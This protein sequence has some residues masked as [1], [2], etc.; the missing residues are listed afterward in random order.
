MKA[1]FYRSSGFRYL[2]ISTTLVL[3]II[4]AYLL[5]IKPSDVK[6][7]GS[8]IGFSGIVVESYDGKTPILEAEMR[9]YS[10]AWPY[11]ELLVTIDGIDYAVDLGLFFPKR[12]NIIWVYAP[13]HVNKAMLMFD[14]EIR[15]L[16]GK[17]NVN[18]QMD[19]I[20]DRSSNEL[21]VTVNDNKDNGPYKLV[22]DNQND[23]AVSVS[24]GRPVTL[25]IDMTL[26]NHELIVTDNLS[27]STSFMFTLD[28]DSWPSP[29][30]I[31]TNV[32]PS[33]H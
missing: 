31:T 18:F 29:F 30:S 14:K 15:T 3:A 26:G 7:F 21:I 2:V 20:I 28:K 23:Q 22:L 8:G 9:V 24:W 6:H 33:I 32:N 10:L 19:T 5:G 11:K 12:F 4:T 17:S 1:P 25:S 27:K 13:G 16:D